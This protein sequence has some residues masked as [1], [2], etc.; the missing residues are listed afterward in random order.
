[1][2][3]TGPNATSSLDLPRISRKRSADTS[4]RSDRDDSFPERAHSVAVNL[5]MLS[6]NSDSPQKHYLGSSSGLLFTNL[7]GAS[8]SSAG[9]TPRRASDHVQANDTPDWYDQDVGSDHA[10]LYD[11]SFSQFLRQ[12]S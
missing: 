6:L 4:M 5:G 3:A 2:A 11:R 10:R 1:M 7:L 12:V 8:P 9:S